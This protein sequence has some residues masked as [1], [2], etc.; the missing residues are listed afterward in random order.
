[1]IMKKNLD[2]VTRKCAYN[3][4]STIPKKIFSVI[5]FHLPNAKLETNQKIKNK[6]SYALE[7]LQGCGVR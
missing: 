1:M 2:K 5:K 4:N 6:V 3:I 7:V